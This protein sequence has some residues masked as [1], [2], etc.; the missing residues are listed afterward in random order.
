[1]ASPP[2]SFIFSSTLLKVT[3]SSDVDIIITD[4]EKEFFKSGRIFPRC[5]LFEVSEIYF[6]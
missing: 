1:M 2:S 3:Y 5:F 6:C 4:R